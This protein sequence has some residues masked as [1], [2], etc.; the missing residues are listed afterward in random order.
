MVLIFTLSRSK[1]SNRVINW[2]KF[3]S[4]SSSSGVRNYPCNFNHICLNGIRAYFF[5][6]RK[7]DVNHTLYFCLL[8]ILLSIT[9]TI[10]NSENWTF[11]HP[12][13]GCSSH[14]FLVFQSY[15]L[16]STVNDPIIYKFNFTFYC[17]FLSAAH[18]KV[19]CFDWLVRCTLVC[20]RSSFTS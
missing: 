13:N 5:L 2:Q 4:P 18:T 20:R 19:G 16:T 3:A 11:S 12:W 8:S 17:I 14:R 1:M 10:A 6:Y 9:I 7:K 15:K